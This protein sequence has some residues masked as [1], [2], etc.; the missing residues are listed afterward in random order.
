[1]SKVRGQISFIDLNDGKSLMLSLEAN[2]PSI[3]IFNVDAEQTSDK[4]APDYTVSPYLVLSPVLFVSGELTNQI[5]HAATTPYWTING[6]PVNQYDNRNSRAQTSGVDNF[7]S[8]EVLFATSSPYE[9]TIKVN[10]SSAGYS[11]LFVNGAMVIKCALEYY[12]DD[13]TLSTPLTTSITIQQLAVAEGMLN[14]M[15]YSKSGGTMFINKE[16]N[17]VDDIVLHCDMYRGGNIDNTNVVYSWYRQDDP[18]DPTDDYQWYKL[19]AS[20][21]A[22]EADPNYSS[23]PQPHIADPTLGDVGIWIIDGI[24]VIVGSSTPN[25]ITIK[26]AAVTN[27]D[28][29]MCICT[30]NDS[31]QSTYGNHA[32]TVP[33]N[34]LDYT[35]PYT[36]E[37]Q[38]P[39]G[40][41]MTRGTDYLD[42]TVVIYQNGDPLTATKHNA[43]TYTWTKHDKNGVIATGTATSSDANYYLD[44]KF[45]MSGSTLVP[46]EGTGRWGTHDGTY[47]LVA[48]GSNNGRSLRVYKEEIS[49]KSIFKVEILIP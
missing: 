7:K 34:I 43:C 31:S 37:F 6:V 46:D 45:T 41:T 24:T 19:F 4:Y 25:E 38:S 18:D 14:A 20:Q 13:T 47:S 11:P 42:T 33:I 17:T 29:F 16:T 8:D 36:I 15:I 32:P 12:D 49:I 44:H 26:P 23:S 1:M 2:Q 5:S 48:T 22:A 27:Y 3:Q 30:D 39:A 21:A 9:L 35:D 10:E 40:T 28:A